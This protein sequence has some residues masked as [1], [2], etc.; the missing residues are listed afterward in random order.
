MGIVVYPWGSADV[1]KAVYNQGVL[2]EVA[3]FPS[4]V[5]RKA[6]VEVHG[7]VD[8]VRVGLWVV[9]DRPLVVIFDL[10]G[11]LLVITVIFVELSTL[12]DLQHMRWK[13]GREQYCCSASMRQNAERS[14]WQ[15]SPEKQ[16]R[17]MIRL[18]YTLKSYLSNKLKYKGYTTKIKQ[19]G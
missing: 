1:A 15:R 19:K 12:Q 13:P 4:V 14:P 16:E 18:M 5:C 2:T 7:V 9:V 3:L 6:A 8:S 17:V 10:D 11:G